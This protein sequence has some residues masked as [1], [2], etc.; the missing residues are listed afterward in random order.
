MSVP[1]APLPVLFD[2]TPALSGWGGI[3]RYARELA[4]VLARPDS[5]VA[6]DLF[7]ADPKMLAPAPELGPRVR[8]VL[9]RGTR[10]WRLEVALAHLTGRTLDAAVGARAGSLFHATDHLLPPFSPAVRSVITL[11]DLGYVRVPETHAIRNRLYLTAMMGRFL[12]RADAIISVSDFSRREAIA[13]Y[14]LPARKIRVVH[15]GVSD[16]FA[17]SGPEEVLRAR[18]RYAL[19]ERYVL[20]VGTLEPRKNM[21]TALAAWAAAGSRDVALALVGPRGWR[22]RQAIGRE[23]AAGG[24]RPGVI[25]TGHVDDRDLPALYTGASA[26]LFPTLYE[27]FGVPVLEAMACGTPVLSSDAASLPEVVGDAAVLLPPGDVR[28]WAQALRDVLGDPARAADLVARGRDRAAKFPWTKAG[29]ETA[30][31]YEEVHAG[32]A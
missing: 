24:S 32:R 18:T 13:V 14:G 15:P 8:T 30:A 19:P 26:F 3:R 16:L 23:L 4:R 29:R 1:G 25:L 17:P 12:A 20:T 21:T 2:Y 27:G 28:A 5:G 31:V 9:A 11:H 10:T 7:A 22:L 6:V